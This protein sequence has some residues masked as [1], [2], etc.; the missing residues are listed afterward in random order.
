MAGLA[1]STVSDI[2]MGCLASM[3]LAT[4]RRVASQ[5]QIQVEIRGRWRGG[6]S[7]R[8]LNRRHSL[9]AESVARSLGGH[10]GWAFAAE[11]SFSVYGER[12]VVDQIGWH[13]ASR[14]LLMIELKTELVD[15]NEM[16]GTLDRKARLAPAIAAE[17]GW[18]PAAVS[19]WLIVAD[20]R[21]NR[22]HAAQHSTLLRTRFALD[23]RSLPALLRHPSGPTTGLAF[24]TDSAG[25]G[26]R[27]ESLAAR[28]A[29]RRPKRD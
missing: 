14:H 10:S 19:V 25:G 24:W 5:L 28:R 3:S 22:R 1:D 15:V 12:G 27:R 7:E 9:L 13:E 26:A 18:R 2:E 16:L 4:L 23:G 8:L 20:S 6:E 11:V 21:T 17:R 29:V